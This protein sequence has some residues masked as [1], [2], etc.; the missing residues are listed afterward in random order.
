MLNFERRLAAVSK[1]K[2]VY[3]TVHECVRLVFH[4]EFSATASSSH[5]LRSLGHLTRMSLRITG[6]IGNGTTS[7]NLE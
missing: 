7:G 6:N 1:K 5:S 4:G 3:R 2:P